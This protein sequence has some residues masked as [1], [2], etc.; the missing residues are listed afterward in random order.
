MGLFDVMGFQ[1][2]FKTFSFLVFILLN[3]ALPLPTLYYCMSHPYF[4]HLSGLLRF[5]VM[6]FNKQ[7]DEKLSLS[8]KSLSP[9]VFPENR[10]N[11]GITL[12]FSI[13]KGDRQNS[14]LSACPLLYDTPHSKPVALV[15]ASDTN[16]VTPKDPENSSASKV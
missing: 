7:F 15:S 2:N 11:L 8:F 16:T 4:L 9:T 12:Y 1:Y 5:M 14:K 3:P 6:T 10:N 13:H